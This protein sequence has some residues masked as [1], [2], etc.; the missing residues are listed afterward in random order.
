MTSKRV[1]SSPSK[2]ENLSP[3]K[4]KSSA[5]LQEVVWRNALTNM[6]QAVVINN[7]EREIV[8]ANQAF[9]DLV[10]MS[11]S[12][13]IGNKFETVVTPD[14]N[15]QRQLIQLEFERRKQGIAS[16]YDIERHTASGIQYLRINASPMF[17]EEKNFWEAFRSSATLARKSKP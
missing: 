16:V 5:T 17:D 14:D 1:T 9:Y 15:I 6:S 4:Q 7:A 2:E 8:F 10:K 11:E 12:E 13:V 3:T